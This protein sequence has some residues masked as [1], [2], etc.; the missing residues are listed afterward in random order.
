MI[1]TSPGRNY[2]TVKVTTREGLVGHGDAT[3]NGRELAVAAAL[4][5][6][7]V[8]IV[9]GRDVDRIEDTWQYLYKGAY[10]HQGAVGMA[11]LAAIDT[12]LWD[13]KAKRADVPLYQLLGGA[14]RDRCL[15][16]TH[17]FGADLPELFTS[18][19]AQLDRGFRAVRVQVAVPAL[20]PGYG[21]SSESAAYEPARRGGA[22]QEEVWSTPDYLRQVPGVFE[23]VRAEFGPE[24]DLLH[25]VHHRLTPIEAARLGRDLEPYRL[26]WLEDVIGGHDADALRLVRQHTTTPIAMGEVVTHLTEAREIVQGR[27]IDY[28]RATVTHA[29]G[30]THLRRILDFAAVFGVRSGCHGPSD[31]SPI[32]LAA[33][34]HIGLAI[35]NFGIQEYMGHN[36]A[37]NAVFPHGYTL[38][39]GALHPGDLP[40]HGA[41]IDT[42]LAL[43]H[44]YERAYL[45]VNRLRDGTLHDW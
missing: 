45:P 14:S 15:A 21:V 3:L 32:G 24:L 18:I 1:V 38:Q 44:P 17:A 26:F 10:W 43:E 16:Y 36:D 31:I 29:G 13:I 35:P 39:D 19:R 11:G 25:D 22:P 33:A 7:L 27:L 28:L 9:V 20:G 12:A 8:P 2:V 5:E 37:T 4:R 42:A 6:H 40:G 30:V 34:L 23:A 41:E